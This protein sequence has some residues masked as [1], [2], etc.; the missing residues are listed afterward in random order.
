MQPP[1]AFP[2]QVSQQVLPGRT[3]NKRMQAMLGAGAV[4]K[5]K[6]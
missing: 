5:S 3:G 1:Y 6:D 2:Q 4:Q